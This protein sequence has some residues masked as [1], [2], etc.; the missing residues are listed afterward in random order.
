[1]CTEKD[2]DY[3]IAKVW[4]DCPS[5]SNFYP[6]RGDAPLCD[7]CGYDDFADFRYSEVK[8]VNEAV[9]SRFSPKTEVY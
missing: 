2:I 5:C 6:S 8:L 7:V 3:S 1:M 4:I 9:A